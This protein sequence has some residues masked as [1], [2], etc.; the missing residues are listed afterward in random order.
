M[1]DATY[2]VF[3]ITNRE[4]VYDILHLFLL[5]AVAE[6]HCVREVDLSVV[7]G[8]VRCVDVHCRVSCNSFVHAQGQNFLLRSLVNW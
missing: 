6:M 5:F 2:V 3:Q 7:F 4:V 8:R 1:K